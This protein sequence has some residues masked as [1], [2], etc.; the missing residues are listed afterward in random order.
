MHLEGPWLS[1]SGKKRGK[2]KFRNAEEARKSRELADS[3]TALQKKWG[4]D[5]AKSPKKLKPKE[6]LSYKLDVPSDRSTKHIPSRDSGLGVATKKESQKYTGTLIKG[7]ATMHKS[8]AV[9]ILNDQEAQDIA[10]MR[11]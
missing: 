10:K 11:R 1:T 9:P 7:I 5:A 2:K 6:T 3:W 8:N 4:V